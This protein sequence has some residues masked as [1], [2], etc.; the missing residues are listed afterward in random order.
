MINKKEQVKFLA[1]WAKQ[2]IGPN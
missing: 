2:A 1:M